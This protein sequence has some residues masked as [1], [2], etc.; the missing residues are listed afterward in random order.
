L[1]AIGEILQALHMACDLIAGMDGAA[2]H[3]VRKTLNKYNL[4]SVATAARKA[5]ENELASG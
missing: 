3:E 2:A 4:S 5:G 1:L